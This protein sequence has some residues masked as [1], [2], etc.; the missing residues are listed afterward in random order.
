MVN[1]LRFAGVLS[2][3]DAGVRA[4]APVDG[5]GLLLREERGAFTFL[6][7]RSWGSSGYTFPLT[8]LPAPFAVEQSGPVQY[9]PLAPMLDLA[10][11]VDA[12]FAR[13]GLER[14]T[15]VPLPSGTGRLWTVTRSIGRLT[16]GQLLEHVALAGELDRRAGA[17]ETVEQS[18]GRLKRLDALESL[19]PALADA[20]DVR[21]I[22]NRLAAIV[23]DILPHDTLELLM[24]TGDRQRA[25]FH[26]RSGS[27]AP[28]LPEMVELPPNMVLT[29]GWR[30]FIIDDLHAHP[31]EA[32]LSAAA[33]G[34]RSSL[35]VPIRLRDRSPAGLN[36]MSLEARR[37]SIE[38]LFVALRLAEHLAL[39]LSHA[40][41]AEQS[42]RGAALR[43]QAANLELLDGLLGTLTGV[44]DIR[45]VFDHVSAIARK[46]LAHDAMA[47]TIVLQDPLRLRVHA[48]SGF[49]DFPESFEMPMPEPGLVTVPWDFRIV[50]LPDDPRYAGSPTVA[51]GMAS[52][53]GLPIR[54]NGRLHA[55]VNFY[56]R[57]KGRF[58]R[59]QVLVARRIADHVALALSHQRLAEEVRE[60]DALRSRTINLEL[61][62]DL[63]AALPDSGELNEVFERVSAIAQKVLAHDAM[64]LP[65]MLADG[66]HARVYAS[67]GVTFP[68]VVE[69]PAAFVRRD[70][71]EHDLVDDM[72]A[73]PDQRNLA[74][75]KRGYRSA[76]RVPI[77]LD[78]TLAA[79]LAFLS[80]QPATFTPADVLVAR[81]IADR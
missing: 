33:A 58:T 70:Q 28:A 38:D 1:R 31:E 55:G 60:A 32:Q 11:P 36:V 63:L 9:T 2:E 49:D 15:I 72:R 67:S 52:V 17:P 61:L 39:A 41:L 16:E 51:A 6:S 66:I 25:R 20:L 5:F 30:Y 26:A 73:Q 22:F 57:S 80:L 68:D 75:A 34:F 43:E 35:R 42:R 48:I 40:D 65:V 69:M 19:L 71:W 45:G 14:L 62:D 54:V 29:D 23:G 77:R 59:D 47:V 78:G 10:R 12:M 79:G 76:L 13:A 24:P 21:D 18:L 3:L 74:A 37:Y 56:S 64:T 53:L 27:H 46:V 4:I 8:D 44:L 81:R 50:D 7:R